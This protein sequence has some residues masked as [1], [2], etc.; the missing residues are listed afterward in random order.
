MI[1]SIVR[2]PVRRLSVHDSCGRS[3]P[4]TAVGC[5]EECDSADDAES[6]EEPGEDRRRA[7]AG[8]QEAAGDQRGKGGTKCGPARGLPRR[9]RRRCPVPG[10]RLP[11]G[12]VRP[13]DR[14]SVGYTISQICGSA[15][16]PTIATALFAATKTSDPIV[17]Y[18]RWFR[19]SPSSRLHCCPALGDARKQPPKQR[20]SGQPT[21]YRAQHRRS[22]IQ[23]PGR[24][25]G[26]VDCRPPRHPRIRILAAASQSKPAQWDQTR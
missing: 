13:Q 14:A 1:E 8:K 12:Q 18:R 26:M 9:T 7:A 24:P 6:T 22:M 5:E 20:A 4:R 23:D 3:G 15:F 16:A 10:V 25:A 21:D 17:I 2:G 11:L 19:P